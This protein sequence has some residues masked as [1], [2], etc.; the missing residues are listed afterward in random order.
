VG[1]DVKVK[2]RKLYC[3]T[4]FREIPRQVDPSHVM[5]RDCSMFLAM[6]RDG[7]PS[8][9]SDNE[10]TSATDVTATTNLPN[11]KSIPLSPCAYTDNSCDSC[12]QHAHDNRTHDHKAF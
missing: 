3:L 12:H 2:R 5:P 8:K 4:T 9:R 7:C 11:I 6:N 1:E 10:P